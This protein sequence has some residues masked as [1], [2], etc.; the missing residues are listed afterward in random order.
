LKNTS[1]N[2]TL[3]TSGE[4]AKYLG[5][6]INTVRRWE[7]KGI[8]KSYRVDPKGYRWFRREDIEV[9]INKIGKDFQVKTE[10]SSK[11]REILNKKI[12]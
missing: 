2:K 8:L 11:F 10:K 5:V 7:Q 12:W 4:V 1:D 9:F 3:L 6:H